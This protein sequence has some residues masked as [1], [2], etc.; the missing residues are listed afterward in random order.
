[1]R[2]YGYAAIFLACVA[3][4]PV[5][6]AK[7]TFIHNYK[8]GSYGSSGV[9]TGPDGTVYGTTADGGGSGCALGCG[10]I[11]A[12]KPPAGGS[13]KWSYNVLYKFQNGRDGANPV[14]S[15]TLGPNGVLYGT[16]TNPGG[17]GYPAFSLAPPTN[18]GGAW[19]FTVLAIFPTGVY[20]GAAGSNLI[21]SNGSLYGITSGGSTNCPYT[22]CGTV[23]RLSQDQ[24]GAWSIKTL[25]A[26]DGNR[27]GGSP[28]SI[29]G[30]DSTGAFYV[31]NSYG[32]RI[33]YVTP[34][35]SRASVRV[36]TGT[37]RR[38][39]ACLVL[40]SSGTLYGASFSNGLG[41]GE[42]FQIVPNQGGW[43][44]TRLLRIRDHQ[45]SPCPDIEGPGGS[46]L[47]TVFGDQDFYYG[48]VFQITPPV[49]QGSWIFHN[50]AEFGRTGRYG[51]SNV[52]FGYKGSLY[53]AISQAY[54]P[55][56]GIFELKYG[57]ADAKS[58]N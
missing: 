33:V 7:L 3:A 26:F 25:V 28:V 46:L 53:G 43:T 13:T 34:Q 51:P 27:W 1:M 40:A 12:L 14:A 54:G 41:A 15:L 49:G 48:S 39:P 10:T 37:G 52:V 32:Y 4:Q 44:R 21:Y 8:N 47:G 38:V 30:P 42:L 20:P 17:G 56:P 58:A 29:A 36:V 11:Y 19:N 2:R 18:G 9:I 50:L 45:F 6:A 5:R 24:G 16:S 35:G 23:F 55:P 31:A 57:G 22:G